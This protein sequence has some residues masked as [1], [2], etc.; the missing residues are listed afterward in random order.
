MDINIPNLS[1]NMSY[2]IPLIGVIIVVFL[3][4]TLYLEKSDICNIGLASI[5]GNTSLNIIIVLL[6][7]SF[8]VLAVLLFNDRINID[9]LFR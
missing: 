4:T 1:Y 8:I 2:D 3:M 9:T 7:I 5:V 6:A